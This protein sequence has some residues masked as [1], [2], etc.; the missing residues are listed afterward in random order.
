MFKPYYSWT[1][2][3]AIDTHTD[4]NKPEGHPTTV[5]F[6]VIKIG[7]EKRLSVCFSLVFI[8]KGIRYRSEFHLLKI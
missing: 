7:I 5:L 2:G 8:I 3:Q 4:Y 6:T 1:P